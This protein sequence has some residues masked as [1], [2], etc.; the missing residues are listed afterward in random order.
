MKIYQRSSL[1][2]DSLGRLHSHIAI[3][4]SLDIIILISNF[5]SSAN[6]RTNGIRSREG[7]GEGKGA[8]DDEGR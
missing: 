7:K 6:E 5:P 1:V 8:G 4:S 3:L 2:G